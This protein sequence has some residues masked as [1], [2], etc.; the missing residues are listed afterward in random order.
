[1]KE[2]ERLFPENTLSKMRVSPEALEEHIRM[3]NCQHV[4]D[5][6]RITILQED[7]GSNV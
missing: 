5:K 1:M 2:L 7:Q 4:N 3:A 6:K